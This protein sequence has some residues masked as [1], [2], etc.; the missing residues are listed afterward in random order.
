MLID[1]INMLGHLVEYYKIH[2]MKILAKQYK[3]IFEHSSHI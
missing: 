3:H 2:Q 1:I